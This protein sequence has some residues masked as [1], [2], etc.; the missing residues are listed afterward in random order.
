MPRALEV[1]VTVQNRERGAAM[2]HVL[3]EE[4]L[5]ACVNIVGG[6]RSIYRWRN[7]ISDD[8]EALCLIKTRPELFAA[9]EARVKALHTYET[10]EILAFEVVEGSAAYLDWLEE[11][12]TGAGAGTGAEAGKP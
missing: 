9:L 10:P 1:H 6:V 3:V 8:E 12:T 5:A 7:E 11:A 2:A 4:R